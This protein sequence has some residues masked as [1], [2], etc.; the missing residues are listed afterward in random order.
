M[1]IRDRY[2]DD[3]FESLPRKRLEKTPNQPQR[4][5]KTTQTKGTKQTVNPDQKG[6]VSTGK[7]LRSTSRSTKINRSEPIRESYSE[8]GRKLTK[9]QRAKVVTKK[10]QKIGSESLLEIIKNAAFKAQQ[11]GDL[12][13]LN[14]SEIDREETQEEREARKLLN[15]HVRTSFI[16]KAVRVD[17]EKVIL[18]HSL[19]HDIELTCPQKRDKIDWISLADSYFIKMIERSLVRNGHELFSEKA[20]REELKEDEEN[21]FEAKFRE[22]YPSPKQQVCSKLLELRKAISNLKSNSKCPTIIS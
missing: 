3:A 2:Y 14:S 10:G 18:K 22:S 15:E 5:L 19:N 13:N 11:T 21:F 9:K 7:D 6:S 16:K 20:N 17:S 8:T 4:D 1:C 12:S